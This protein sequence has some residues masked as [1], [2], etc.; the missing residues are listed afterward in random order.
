M[1]SKP[2][3]VDQL[4]ST[5]RVMEH[6][7]TLDEPVF[8]SPEW[9]EEKRRLSSEGRIYDRAAHDYFLRKANVMRIKGKKLF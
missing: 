4:E 3:T 1:Y 8:Y 5:K 9:E 6:L 2:L 7:L